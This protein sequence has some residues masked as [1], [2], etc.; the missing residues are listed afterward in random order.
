[1]TSR[2]HWMPFYPCDYLGDTG[3]LSTLEHGAYLLLIMHYWMKGGLPD[4]EAQLARICRLQPY[5]WRRMRDTMAGLFQDGWKHKR[6][7]GELAKAEAK[8]EARSEAAKRTVRA[9]QKRANNEANS[10]KNNEAQQANATT[11]TA[12][13]EKAPSASFS[14][15]G[16]S[17]YAPGGEVVSLG[18]P[19]PP[20][21]NGGGSQPKAKKRRSEMSPEELVAQ[22]RADHE[23]AIRELDEERQWRENYVRRK[24]EAE[25]AGA[26][27][28]NLQTGRT[29]DDVCASGNRDLALLRQTVPD[30]VGE[31]RSAA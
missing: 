15:G 10:L 20:P 1:M 29:A 19:S 17:R 12:T 28:G 3:H 8:R 27:N 6:I 23:Q 24:R 25:A 22:D 14:L 30:T 11:V 18:L 7:D 5:R 26:R 16:S 21:L 31:Q 4:D 2:C 13:K 9:L